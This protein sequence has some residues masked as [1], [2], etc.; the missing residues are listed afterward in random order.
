MRWT[1]TNQLI[2][3]GNIHGAFGTVLNTARLSKETRA[4]VKKAQLTAAKK[5][6]KFSEYLKKHPNLYDEAYVE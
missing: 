4:E 2:M 3:L 1:Y 5:Y 6:L